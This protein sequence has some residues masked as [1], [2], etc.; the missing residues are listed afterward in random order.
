[1]WTCRRSCRFHHWLEILLVGGVSFSYSGMD[2]WS[3]RYGRGKRLRTLWI[4]KS[5]HLLR[6]TSLSVYFHD[7]ARCMA[8]PINRPPPTQ[9]NLQESFSEINKVDLMMKLKKL[10]GNHQTDSL[11][12]WSSTTADNIDGITIFRQYRASSEFIRRSYQ[13]LALELIGAT[14]LRGSSPNL[15]L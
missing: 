12:E 11:K 5:K 14:R 7:L 8:S 13:F 3:K 1:M 9:S 4:P 6:L 2:C 10:T 15:I